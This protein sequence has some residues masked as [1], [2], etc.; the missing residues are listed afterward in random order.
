MKLKKFLTQTLFCIAVLFPI[1]AENIRGPVSGVLEPSYGKAEVLESSIEALVGLVLS[2]PVSPLLQGVKITISADEGLT[3]YRNSFALYLYKNLDSE[4]VMERTSYKGTQTYM[5]FMDFG[6]PVSFIIPLSD[7][8]TLSPDRTTFLVSENNKIDEFPLIM[9]ILP[10]TKGIP[11]N[12]YNNKVTYQIEPVYFQKGIVSLNILNTKGLPVEETLYFQMDGNIIEDL[13][14]ETIVDAGLHSLI[15]RSESGVEDTIEFAIS[16]GQTLILDHVLQQQFPVLRIN[17]LEGM[18]VYLDERP[19]SP[20]ELAQS[21]EI[22]PGHHIIRFE[23]GDYQLSREFTAE[24]RDSL[25]ITMI[26]EIQLDKQ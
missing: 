13:T 7:T 19:V 1:T 5:R 9:T 22:Q 21:F 8:H 4:P 24:M 11:D 3:L 2:P 23:I 15:I 17:T 10:I 16:A 20:E 18:E 14:G 26:P 6:K 12:V 25:R